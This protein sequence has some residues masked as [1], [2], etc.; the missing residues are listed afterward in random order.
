MKTR[1][2]SK[3]QAKDTKAVNKNS[4]K[5]DFKIN[6]IEAMKDISK[7]SPEDNIKNKKVCKNASLLTYDKNRINQLNNLIQIMTTNEKVE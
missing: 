3:L 7:I 2:G 6:K 5:H 4:A 1:N